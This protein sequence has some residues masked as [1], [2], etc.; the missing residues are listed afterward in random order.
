MFF[1]CLQGPNSGPP[2]PII[3]AQQP[4]VQFFHTYKLSFSFL[5]HC[6]NTQARTI[7]HE[8]TKAKNFD[9]AFQSTLVI[10]SVAKRKE[11]SDEGVHFSRSDG[12]LPRR[13]IYWAEYA[14][15]V[16]GVKNGISARQEIA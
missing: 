5:S 14:V 7:L 8:R 9:D 10:M 12:R 11:E 2:H 15:S 1:V 16:Y 6:S 4:C 3:L 13:W